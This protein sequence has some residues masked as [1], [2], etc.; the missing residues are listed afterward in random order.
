M[1]IISNV[2]I[3]RNVLVNPTW[4]SNTVSPIID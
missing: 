2:F 3:G 4:E 1:N